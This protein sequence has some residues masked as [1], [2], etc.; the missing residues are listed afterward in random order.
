MCKWSC[1]WAPNLLPS[2]MDVLPQDI[3]ENMLI[4]LEEQ[5][6]NCSHQNG[7]CY[8]LDTEVMRVFGYD[9]MALFN[10]VLVKAM[11]TCTTLGQD[12]WED[13]FQFSHTD[14]FGV[15][16]RYKLSR[17]ACFLIAQNADKTKIQVVLAQYMLA[18]MATVV[19]QQSDIDRLDA[20]NQITRGEKELSSVAKSH[21]IGEGLYDY[22]NFKDAGYRGMYN[23][24]LKQLEKHKG[25]TRQ[26]GRVLYDRM[27]TTELA[28]NLFR[29]TQTTE[30]IKLNDVRG[31]KNL[32]HAAAMIGKK[33]RNMMVTPP[34]QIPLSKTEIKEVKKLG[35]SAKR[36]ISKIDQPPAKRKKKSSNTEDE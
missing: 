16:G 12:P 33:V 21:G 28:A 6:E 14:S 24:S 27:G 25:F 7:I 29:V 1:K 26:G 20:R 30:H 31:Q 5:F 35:K 23:M 11:N 19:L 18:R 22:A 15:Q 34:E 36:N 9:D 17:F 2:G 32:E 10:K 4:D 3:D 8:W 13:F